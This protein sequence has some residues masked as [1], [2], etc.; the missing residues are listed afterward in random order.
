MMRRTLSALV[1]ATAT[2]APV[3]SH[4]SLFHSSTTASSSKGK[5]VKMTLKNHTTA[6]MQ[7]MIEDQPVTIA[8]NGE[9]ALSAPEGTH[10]YGEDKSVKM[11]VTRDLNGTTCTFR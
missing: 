7:L 11:I 3:I 10:I 8:A 6:P 2:F 4:A 9:Y 1:L 5:M